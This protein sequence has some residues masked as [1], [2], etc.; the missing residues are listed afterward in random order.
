MTYHKSAKI[1]LLESIHD[2]NV[3]IDKREV[4]ITPG[5]E[6]CEVD[7]L[8]SADLVRNIRF[9]DSLNSNPIL[10]HMGTAGGDWNYG[11]MIYDAI[12][13]SI[14]RIVTISYAHARS[15]SSIIPQAADLR[16]IAPHAD[17]MIHEGSFDYMGTSKGAK[18]NVGWNNYLSEVMISL[19]VEKCQYGPHFKGWTEKRISKFLQ[20]KMDKNED[21]YM[22]PEESVKYGF[23]DGILGESGFEDIETIMSIE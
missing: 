13:N 10:I 20:D 2:F 21:W 9:L 4:F 15:M 14:S 12:A 7:C 11:M 8:M 19:Y 22:T 1:E 23:M 16:I 18:H 5:D 3:N 17:F 6:N